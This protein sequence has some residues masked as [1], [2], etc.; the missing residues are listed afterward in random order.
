M[1]LPTPLRPRNYVLQQCHAVQDDTP[2]VET[3]I[4]RS[5]REME[6]SISQ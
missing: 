2:D 5:E 6:D 1:P 4:Q 3:D